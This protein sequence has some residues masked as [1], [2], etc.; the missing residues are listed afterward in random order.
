MA[1][2]QD[3]SEASELARDGDETNREPT[4]TE[5]ND[6]QPNPT[7]T[8]FIV[9]IGASAGGLEPIEQFFDFMPADTGMSFVVVQHLSPD[10]KSLMP[11]LLARHTKMPI[12]P[13]EDGVEVEPNNIYLI[14]PRKTMVLE[15]RHLR[16]RD[17]VSN[18]KMELPID[19]FFESLAQHAADRGI[20]V[21]L[22]G[23]GSDGSRG[24]KSVH[25]AG[26]LVVGQVAST[27]GFDG[28]P[29]SAKATGMVDVIC[30][31][32]AM[33]D[34]ILRY[35]QDPHAFRNADGADHN[36]PSDGNHIGELFRLF[37]KQYSIDFEKYRPTTIE[38]R[39]DRRVAMGHYSG[40]EEYAR[41]I[42]NDPEEMDA[43]FRD[44]L[45]EVT[46]FFR[47]RPAFDRLTQEVIPKIL[48]QCPRDG[49]VRIWVPAC[50]TGEEAYSIAM[51]AAELQSGEINRADVEIKVFA[52][53]VHQRSLEAASNGVYGKDSV[54]K[55]PKVYRK[56]FIVE[57][58]DRYVVHPKIRQMVIFAPHDITSDPA[59]TK[60]DLISCRNALIYLESPVQQKV[61]SL[62][63]FGL[64][65]GGYLFLGPSETLADLAGEFDVVDSHWRIFRKKRNVRLSEVND[66]LFPPAIRPIRQ[67]FPSLA[68][69]TLESSENL[70]DDVRDQLLR[71]YVPPSLLVND[72]NELVHSYGDARRFLRQPEGPATLD[73][74]RMLDGDLRMAV[75][76]VLHRVRTGG[77][78]T[79]RVDAVA[80]GES[81]AN[82][83][84]AG[85][86]YPHRGRRMVLLMLEATDK[87]P[88]QRSEIT[89]DSTVTTAQADERIR[90]LES[91]L[92]FTKE[93][94]QAAVEELETSNEEL[95]S[96]NEELVAS[97]EE[98]QSTNEE[99]HSVNEEL[100]TVNTE[101]QLKIQELMQL[102]DDM[103]NLLLSTRIG[104]IF[105]DQDLR[106]RKFTPAI[107]EAFY[108]L[109]QD[110]GRPIRH[111]ATNLDLFN[112]DE[113]VRKV[114]RTGE[115]IEREA[116]NRDN[117]GF[118]LRIQPYKG[119]DSGQGVVL[120][121]VDISSILGSYDDIRRT[122]ETF[123]L[124]DRDLQ[125]FAYAV[126]H[127]LQAP[128][129]HIAS[130]VRELRN[131]LGEDVA[132]SQVE[133]FT[134][135]QTQLDRISQMIQGLLRY[136]RIYSRGRP[137]SEVRLLNVLSAAED[138]L[139]PLIEKTDAVIR[140]ES[141][142]KVTGDEEQLATL[143]EELLRNAIEFARESPPR[144]KIVADRI[145]NHLRIDIIDNSIGIAPQHRERVFV[146]FERLEF[147][148]TEGIGMGLAVCRRIMQ[149]HGGSISIV[150]GEGGRGCTFRLSF[151]MFPQDQDVQRQDRGRL[152]SDRIE[153]R[154]SGRSSAEADD[155]V[156]ADDSA[157]FDIKPIMN[158]DDNG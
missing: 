104:T 137:F 48:R 14:P 36:Y 111:I 27:A 93:S 113:D 49:Q 33:P 94:L 56:K 95:Q 134:I 92:S 20:A 122:V 130:Q 34:A 158:S 119:S 115:A 74:L 139:K 23:A 79:V 110:L 53:D 102:T 17:R 19:M 9:G 83:S 3:L 96:T 64:R 66:G 29:R 85:R 58:D 156:D 141:L 91:E 7:S 80:M 133:S 143:F 127:D 140:S 150:D 138:R 99:L 151:P 142:P 16:L 68:A 90:E 39:I 10:F 117:R 101:H 65:V 97:N 82:V 22:S 67:K 136:S 55:L 132:E 105:L 131:N 2:P 44:L 57:K 15:G 46:E 152:T 114:L 26:G 41:R 70:L 69:K 54:E 35:A 25:A 6:P 61:L 145:H 60:L 38:R 126:S 40:L 153:D 157:A 128:V 5:K 13:V 73:V 51:I 43:L 109:P 28:M 108:V 1:D 8:H 129:R 87:Q 84:V 155:S 32:A 71:E 81:E 30:N 4:V 63:H 31:A 52:T 50:A 18:D 12:H 118:L 116:R 112:L 45:V 121:C 106:I 148:T 124:T 24:L 149:R 147:R 154:S 21:I 120:T 98:L 78:Q 76:A 11:E 88:T 72:R 62:F 100:H 42:R 144:I 47:D 59:F 103:D 135:I 86:P 75:S 77:D 125:E 89:I 37:R 123:E 146:I 107:A